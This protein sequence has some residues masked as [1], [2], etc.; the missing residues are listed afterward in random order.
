M[1][2]LRVGYGIGT[3][4]TIAQLENLHM[5]NAI[6]APAI[7]AA[8]GS[9]ADRGHIERERTR[10]AHV[11]AFTIAQLSEAGC[12]VTDSQTNFIFANL[13]GSAA[14]FRA[15]CAERGVVIGRAFEPLGHDHVRISIG[16]LD[17]MRTAL[18][19]FRTVLGSKRESPQ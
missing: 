3:S 16:T 15:G 8:I 11:R 1:A 9:L 4:A 19:V 12:T 7:A 14:A 13:H 18:L 5:P 17:E 10:N 6:C 2:G